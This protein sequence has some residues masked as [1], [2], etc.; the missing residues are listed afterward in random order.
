MFVH[1]HPDGL[2]KHSE[3]DDREEAKLF[4]TAYIRIS[5]VGPHA[6]LLFTDPNQVRGRVWLED[7]RRI[8]VERIRAIGRRFRFFD[9]ELGVEP[10]PVFFDRQI[11]AFGPEIQRLLGRLIVGVVGTG[12]TGSAVAEQL[13]RLGVGSLLLADGQ[14][15]EASNVNRVYGSRIIDEGIAKV[16]I[17]ERLS[18]D[19]GLGTR[20]RVIEK[21]ITSEVAAREL[22]Q[23]D[24]VF[25][26]TDDEW[27]RSILTR[28]AIYYL[29]PVF[30]MGVKIDSEEQKIRAI[31]ARV[32]ALL[33]GAACLFCR[34]RIEPRRIRAESL[35]ATNPAEAE[36]LRQEGYIPQLAAPAPAIIPFTTTIAAGA[37]NEM[38]HRLTGHLG[39][40]RVSTEIIYQFHDNLIRTNSRQPRPGCFCV[41][42]GRIGRAD[43]TPFLDTLWPD[44]H[45]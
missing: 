1:S 20:I 23:C 22:R 35:S 38:L 44:D 39:D 40:E 27:G 29:I 9:N 13:I 32:T 17:V 2:P 37:I 28:L 43:S 25:G 31:E 26:C 45:A 41:D 19:I 42:P 15:F 18:A 11:R 7:G 5:E 6:S 30:D 8:D 33:P 12:G 36:Q 21:D 3:Q 34:E 16:K 4:R 14:T 24:L 10:N